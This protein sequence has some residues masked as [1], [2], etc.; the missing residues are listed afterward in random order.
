M[1]TELVHIKQLHELQHEL[2]L[3]KRAAPN[4]PLDRRHLPRR[5]NLLTS[6]PMALPPAHPA[7]SPPFPFSTLRPVLPTPFLATTKPRRVCV[8]KRA[9]AFFAFSPRFL[10]ET[11]VGPLTLRLEMSYFRI[12]LRW[13][14]IK[15]WSIYYY[16]FKITCCRPCLGRLRHV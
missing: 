10:R 15:E 6:C 1:G 4:R 5:L 12:I 2:V 9:N 14:D 13:R 3:S 11:P 7:L 8:I 16:Y